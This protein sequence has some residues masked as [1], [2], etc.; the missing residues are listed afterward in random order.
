MGVVVLRRNC[1]IN[2]GSCPI[3]VIVLMGRCPEGVFVHR[4]NWQRV[5]VLGRLFSYGVVAPGVVVPRAIVPRV[6]CLQGSCPRTVSMYH[7]T[8]RS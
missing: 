8:T 2:E 1:P 5:L 3:E 7:T 6:V 4:G